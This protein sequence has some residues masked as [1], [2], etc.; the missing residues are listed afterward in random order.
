[1]HTRLENARQSTCFVVMLLNLLRQFVT[2]TSSGIFRAFGGIRSISSV[3]YLA[4][5]PKARWG[6]GGSSLPAPLSSLRLKLLI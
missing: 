4:S 6:D 5:A 3:C 1:M 2:E